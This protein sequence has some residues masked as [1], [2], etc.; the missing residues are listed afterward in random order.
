MDCSI[1]YHE[2]VLSHSILKS[3]F[4]IYVHSADLQEIKKNIIKY[5]LIKCE[6]CE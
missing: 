2:Q 4:L 6:C 3:L 5:T 1:M